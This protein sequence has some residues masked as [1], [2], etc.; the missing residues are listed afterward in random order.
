M[1]SVLSPFRKHDKDHSK[2]SAPA[3]ADDD[4][5]WDDSKT[6]KTVWSSNVSASRKPKG[7][8][9]S[10]GAGIHFLKRGKTFKPISRYLGVSDAVITANHSS[11]A[12]SLRD[13][14]KSVAS[15][16]PSE[17]SQDL[18]NLLNLPPRPRLSHRSGSMSCLP[19]K[20]MRASHSQSL[21]DRQTSS[22]TASTEDSNQLN[23]SLFRRESERGSKK[24]R[25]DQL[26]VPGALTPLAKATSFSHLAASAQQDWKQIERKSPPNS[27]TVLEVAASPPSAP[28]VASCRKRGVGGSPLFSDSD[29][30]SSQGCISASRSSS[31]TSTRRMR[32]RSR[33]FSPDGPPVP[34]LPFSL[35]ALSAVDA[36]TNSMHMAS[37]NKNDRGV[38]DI[39]S[40][41]DSDDDVSENGSPDSSL[42]CDT[43][44]SLH[45][46]HEVVQQVEN[47]QDI[48]QSMSSYSHL[49]F[50]IKTLRSEAKKKPFAFG[51]A[52]HWAVAPRNTW[53]SNERA[54]FIQWASQ[55]LGFDIRAVG[56]SVC[57]L[58][59]SKQ[60]GSALLE[61]LEKALVAYKASTSGQ[62]PATMDVVAQRYK[63]EATLSFVDN[64]AGRRPS[65]NQ[66]RYGSVANDLIVCIWL[67]L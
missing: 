51:A 20:P 2:S 22:T 48:V 26:S 8:F 23:G 47:E 54:A 46:E 12:S 29:E 57:F 43:S 5:E 55:K 27:E 25:T 14:K 15:E 24:I 28:S 31:S 13:S 50:L 40:D 64:L 18:E 45:P 53:Q 33:V 65:M 52:L 61:K 11:P 7:I 49:K 37:P 59:I 39:D 3:A 9:G 44:M 30:M 67:G 21:M 19:P 63:G 34:M 36:M 66:R 38:M 16:S 41:H 42:D 32:R 56:G 62:Q 10:R 60:K 1:K 4:L 6:T 17:V 58:S 35:P